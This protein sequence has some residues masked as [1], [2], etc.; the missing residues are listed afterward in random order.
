[1]KAGKSRK[2]LPLATVAIGSLLA[3][4]GAP[5]VYAATTGPTAPPPPVTRVTISMETLNMRIDKLP[6]LADLKDGDLVTI[7]DDGKVTDNVWSGTYVY[8]PAGTKIQPDHLYARW[9]DGLVAIHMGPD[10]ADYV[11]DHNH[12]WATFVEQSYATTRRGY[13]KDDPGIQL[14]VSQK[15]VTKA[16]IEEPTDRSILRIPNNAFLFRSEGK[17]VYTA[18][19]DVFEFKSGTVPVKAKKLP[20]NMVEVPFGDQPLG[21][22]VQ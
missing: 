8:R 15:Q 19:V 20:W 22:I 9:K 1:M 5:Q 3:F 17:G 12:Y 21:V 6:E 18:L 14:P 4:G 16:L 10:A 11:K 13:I 7:F 2:L